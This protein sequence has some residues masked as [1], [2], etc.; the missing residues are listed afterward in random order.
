MDFIY[1]LGMVP[2][3][4]E[5][6]ALSRGQVIV[7]RD[8]ILSLLHAKVNQLLIEVLRFVSSTNRR[9]HLSHIFVCITAHHSSCNCLL[10]L[11]HGIFKCRYL[12]LGKRVIVWSPCASYTAW[13]CYPCRHRSKSP[14]TKRKVLRSKFSYS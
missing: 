2:F 5:R 7:P 8:L 11:V 6:C 4:N 10:R 9:T 14:Q 13:P 12:F 1:S 3:T